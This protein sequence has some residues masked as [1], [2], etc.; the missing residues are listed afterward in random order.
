MQE[1]DPGHAGGAPQGHVLDKG[2]VLA[3]GVL[4]ARQ[5]HERLRRQ[6]QDTASDKG[7]F[8]LSA[9]EEEAERRAWVKK[10]NLKTKAQRLAVP[11]EDKRKHQPK[12]IPFGGWREL[13]SF[14]EERTENFGYKGVWGWVEG[15]GRG[16]RVGMK[17]AGVG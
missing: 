17:T 1:S 10:K 9:E 5:I 12:E 11:G 15:L 3:P 2:D 14:K 7:R 8:G 6:R 13:R 4:K 16:E